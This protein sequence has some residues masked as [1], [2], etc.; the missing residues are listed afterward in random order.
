MRR[1]SGIAAIVVL[2]AGTP[3]RAQLL[4]NPVQ[5]YV[6]KTQLLNNILSNRRATDLS[7]KAQ[8]GGRSATR[9]GA[10]G[11]GSAPRPDPEPTKF[12][13]SGAPLLPAQLAGMAGG[14]PS[15]QRQA[16]QFFES[17]LGL[18]EQTARKDGFPS[19][20][21]AYAF[22]YFVVNSYMTYH[23]LHDVAYEKD[24]RVKRGTDPLDRLRI[25][26]EKKAMAITITEERAVYTQ[27]RELLG[28]NADVRALTDRRKQEITELLAIMLGMNL[29][30]YMQGVNAEDEATIEKA[31]QSARASL[32][33][34]IGAPIDRIKIGT[35]G[36]DQ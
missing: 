6:N 22:E 2:L 30:M 21:L 31:R 10:G 9:G 32:E 19:N 18:Y 33:K 15:R 7:Q 12:A 35:A 34:L 24:P 29:A 26:N 25:L 20:D 17:L 27:F 14:D 4:T 3:A 16:Q 11:A 1:I 23:D 28:A 5:D 8:T 13:S 36:L